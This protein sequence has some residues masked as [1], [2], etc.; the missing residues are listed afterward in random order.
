MAINR[1]T[2]VCA[3]RTKLATYRLI[4]R[5]LQVPR[6]VPRNSKKKLRRSAAARLRHT[7]AERPS[8]SPHGSI[9]S[10]PFPPC[11]QESDQQPAEGRPWIPR[12]RE[13]QRVRDIFR[14]VAR[15]PWRELCAAKYAKIGKELN[16]NS[17]PSSLAAQRLA[18]SACRVGGECKRCLRYH[19]QHPALQTS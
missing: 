3:I 17:D 16:V 4:I 1:G 7:T 10:P 11:S 6:H 13:L 8:S 12:R 9:V 2:R 18:H 15:H 14:P 19:R 5:S